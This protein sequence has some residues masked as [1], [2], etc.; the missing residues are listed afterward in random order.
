MAQVQG[1]QGAYIV[2]YQLSFV[3][4]PFG[5]LLLALLLNLQ[6]ANTWQ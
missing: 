1:R 4:S 2:F 3:S 6:E 5:L